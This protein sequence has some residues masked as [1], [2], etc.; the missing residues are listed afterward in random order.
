MPARVEMGYKERASGK[1]ERV[2]R[3]SRE[4]IR[5]AALAA[6]ALVAAC[7]ARTGLDASPPA[8]PVTFAGCHQQPW[9]LFDLSDA[10][11][12]ESEGI[13]AMRADG[14][15]PHPLTLPHSPAYFPSVSPDGG[16]LLYAT[17]QGQDA[18]GGALLYLYDFASRTASLVVQTPQLTYSALSPDGQTVAYVNGYSLH[19]VAP[20]GSNDRTLLAGPN[21]DGSGYGHPTF[22]DSSTILY[23]TGGIVGSIGVDPRQLPVPERGVV[24][25]RHPHRHRR[26]LRPGVWRRDPRVSVRVAARSLVRKRHRA[27]G[28]AG[29]RVA[30]R[31]RERSVVGS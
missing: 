20:D 25:R 5:R 23:G 11:N 6:F 14:S 29:E 24:A 28:G 31:R 12:P 3:T 7:G 18:G 13:Y 27:R 17:F 9:L 30:E 1:D 10:N 19:D 22:F 8:P 21:S 16:H 4:W 26:V 2:P 15:D